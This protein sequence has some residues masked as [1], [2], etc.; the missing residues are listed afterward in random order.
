MYG[1]QYLFRLVIIPQYIQIKSRYA[2]H[3]EHKVICQLY[4]NKKI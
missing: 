4:L 3:L 1:D 2:I